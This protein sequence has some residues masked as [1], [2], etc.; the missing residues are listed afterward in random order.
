LNITQEEELSRV[1]QK[2][3]ILL[4]GNASNMQQKVQLTVKAGKACLFKKLKVVQL[5]NYIGE[6]ISRF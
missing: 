4:C 1:V 5:H 3:D 2:T 6:V